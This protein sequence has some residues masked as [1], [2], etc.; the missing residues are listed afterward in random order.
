MCLGFLRPFSTDYNFV[1]VSAISEDEVLDGLV[2]NIPI[3]LRFCSHHRSPHLE[4]A[5]QKANPT[6]QPKT[7]A[8]NMWK[9]M[10]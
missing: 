9:L 6:A 3:C 2:G 7:T 4:S 5:A 8:R 1:P 10:S